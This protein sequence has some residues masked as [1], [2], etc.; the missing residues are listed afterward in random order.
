MSKRHPELATRVGPDGR[1]EWVHPNDPPTPPTTPK[2]RLREALAGLLAAMPRCLEPGCTKPATHGTRP[3]FRANRCA[4]HSV[5]SPP[6]EPIASAVA[7]AEA[8]LREVS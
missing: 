3:D 2:A 7:Q 8:A 5:D 6:A 1:R 4:E